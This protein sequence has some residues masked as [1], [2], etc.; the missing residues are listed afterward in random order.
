MRRRK[1]TRLLRKISSSLQ[2]KVR[3]GKRA[4]RRKKKIS[5]IVTQMMTT[6][7][8]KLRRN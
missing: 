7:R 4:R 1:E 2:L 3:K 5:L 6:K 8:L